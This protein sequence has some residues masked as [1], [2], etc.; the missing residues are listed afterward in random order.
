MNFQDE[1]IRKI[2]KPIE[3]RKVGTRRYFTSSLMRRLFLLRF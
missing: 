2:K 1:L 3:E